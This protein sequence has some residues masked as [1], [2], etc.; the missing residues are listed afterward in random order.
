MNNAQFIDGLKQFISAEQ[1][2]WVLAAIRQDEWLEQFLQGSDVFPL[3]RNVLGE[4]PT[5]WSIGKIALFS[6]YR[7][8]FT[9]NSGQSDFQS[10]IMNSANRA[11]E[12]L[13]DVIARRKKPVSLEEYALLGIALKNLAEIKGWKGT[14]E[15]I[16]N[17]DIR[18]FYHSWKTAIVISGDLQENPLQWVQTL[19]V[20]FDD[21]L[22]LGWGIHWLSVRFLP[23]DKKIEITAEILEKASAVVQIE[24]LQRLSSRGYQGWSQKVAGILLENH[25]LLSRYR[26]KVDLDRLTSTGLL[27]Y[28][29]SLQ[30]LATLSSLAGNNSLSESVLRAAQHAMQYW[31]LEGT[32][33]HV[34]LSHKDLDPSQV[35]YLAQ[36]VFSANPSSKKLKQILGGILF[37]HPEAEHFGVVDSLE[38][39]EEPVLLLLKAQKQ[40]SQGNLSVALELGRLA[41]EQFENFLKESWAKH[42]ISFSALDWQ[43]FVQGLIQLGLTSEALRCAEGLLALRPADTQLLRLVSDIHIRLMNEDQAYQAGKMAYELEPDQVDLCRHFAQVCETTRRWQEAQALWKKLIACAPVDNK[44]LNLYLSFVRSS[45]F[46]DDHQTVIQT[47]KVILEQYPDCGEAYGWLGKAYLKLEDGENGIACL[48]R[49]TLLL[50]EDERWWLSLAEYWLSKQDIPSALNTLKSAVMAVPESGSI[51]YHLGNLLLHQHQTSEA[52]IYLRKASALH[53]ENPEIALRLCQALHGLGYL[54]EARRVLENLKGKWNV[55]PEMAYEYSRIA[56]EQKDHENALDALEMAVRTE[57]PQKEWIFE[58]ARFLLDHADLPG[59]QIHFRLEQAETLLRNLVSQSPSDEL[60]LLLLAEVLVRNRKTEEAHAIFSQ[61]AE[62]AEF[63]QSALGWKVLYGLGVT[64]L[65]MGDHEAGVVFLKDAITRQPENPILL[66]DYAEACVKARLYQEAINV[67]EL[68]CRLTPNDVENGEWFARLAIQLE[69]P[70]LAIEKYTQLIEV[71]PHR[72]DLKLALAGL[73]VKTGAIDQASGVLESVVQ[74]ETLDDDLLRKAGY[75]YLSM[76]RLPQAIQAFEKALAVSLDPSPELLKV[77]MR[78]YEQVGRVDDAVRS[79]EMAVRAGKDDPEVHLEYA[80]L[81]SRLGRD[82]LAQTTLLHALSLPTASNPILRSAIHKELAQICW[83][84]EDFLNG[85]MYAEMGLLENPQSI[86]LQYLQGLLTTT[87]LQWEKAQQWVQAVPLEKEWLSETDGVSSLILKGHLSLT[88]QPAETEKVLQLL[89]EGGITSP[90]YKLLKSRYLA[91]AGQYNEARH[92]LSTIPPELDKEWNLWKISTERESLCFSTALQHAREF[93]QEHPELPWGMLEFVKCVTIGKEISQ[94][95]RMLK[96][97]TGGELSPIVDELDWE[98]A[99]QMIQ[100][101]TGLVVSEELRGWSIRLKVAF[102]PTPE[103]L[104]MLAGTVHSAEEASCLIQGL[105]SIGNLQT[106]LQIAH[107]YL[108]NEAVRFQ[109]ALCYM[110]KDVSKGFEIARGLIEEKPQHPLYQALFSFLARD[111]GE[112]DSAYQAILSAIAQY[113]DE[114][115]WYALAAELAIELGN[116][117]D[118][119]FH[120]EKAVS[121]RP[122]RSDYLLELGWAYMMSESYEK[123]AAILLRATKMEPSNS[124]I[125]FNLAQVYKHLSRFEDAITCA[126]R[127]SEVDPTHIQGFILA[128]ELSLEN[129]NLDLA[130]KY[131]EKALER[132]ELNP[133]AVMAMVKVYHHLGKDEQ[134]LS[135]LESM[136]GK[137]PPVLELDLEK[138]SLIYQLRGAQSAYP[139]TLRLVTEFP[140]DAASLALHARVLADLGDIKQAER[141]AFRSLRQEPNQPELTLSLVRMQRNGG[142]LDQAVHLLTQA[143]TL[144]PQNIDLYIELG[145]IYAERREYDLALQTFHHVIRIAPQDPRGYYRTALILRDGKDFAGAEMMLQHAAKLAPDDVTIHRQLVSVMALNLIHKSQEAGAAL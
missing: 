76:E 111:A 112:T 88:Q 2:P 141:F 36:K 113:P 140:E 123:A 94:L 135:M 102:D 101:L 46:A 14:F 18:D 108:K 53:P 136:Q 26:S 47:C 33:Q 145:E 49:A 29:L 143:I 52:L 138:A 34:V 55:H 1:I 74:A 17:R 16:L 23:L 98:K 25:P 3:L 130:R 20:E 54:Q 60:T 31:Q 106:A 85:L 61:L 131:A 15:E 100:K 13:K 99:D 10:L 81:L 40:L 27:Q 39:V 38:N 110:G 58:Y 105:R 7:Q 51:Y 127:A 28:A 116:F 133:K 128:S 137:M 62:N 59:E 118:G 30:Q 78:V 6:L 45:F 87:L 119:V 9:E 90:E 139:L 56:V 63:I 24:V 75:L 72:L 109:Q 11:E 121:L 8:E 92:I 129:G 66:K 89:E 132:D 77:L 93:V 44:N 71:E 48:T 103:H 120:W 95:S 115:E 126:L 122:E 4:D 43:V 80:R 134:S 91:K 21:P 5:T 65:E 144:D 35:E 124:S 64:L 83:K 69:K 96:L 32:L 42:P 22:I 114:P 70:T 107:P 67:G 37:S 19:F 142:Q 41:T 125:W 82:T 84:Q 97:K 79:G 12:L 50:P 104:K 117:E 68:V 73:Q 86:S 57:H